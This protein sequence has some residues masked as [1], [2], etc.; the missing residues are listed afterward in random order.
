MY[1]VD[2]LFGVIGFLGYE[3]IRVYKR[4]RNSLDPFPVNKKYYIVILI[5]VG[6]FSG[7]VSYLLAGGNII[8][9]LFIGFSIPSG[10]KAI[11]DTPR[12]EHADEVDDIEIG[13]LNFFQ[14]ASLWIKNYFNA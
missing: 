1:P 5:W 3:G 7:I 6:L 8:R 13:E 14:R 4:L 11:I 9:A 10:I 12:P 2:I